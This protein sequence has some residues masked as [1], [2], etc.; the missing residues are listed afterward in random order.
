MIPNCRKIDTPFCKM[1]YKKNLPFYKG[2]ILQGNLNLITPG[3]VVGN[4][5]DPRMVFCQKFFPD[6]FTQQG[7]C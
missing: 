7:G 4:P 2:W 1:C 6:R 3:L 5:L